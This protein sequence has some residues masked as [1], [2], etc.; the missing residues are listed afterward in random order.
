MPIYSAIISRFEDRSADEAADKII[1]HYGRAGRQAG[2]AF[3]KELAASLSKNKDFQQVMEQ[4]KRRYAEVGTSAKDVAEYEGLLDRARKTGLFSTQDTLRFEAQ[5][6]QARRRQTEAIKAQRDT[7]TQYQS[8]VRSAQAE[9]AK[10]SQLL[11]EH[12]KKVK[13]ATEEHVSFKE[14]LEGLGRL[15]NTA[16]VGRLGEQFEMLGGKIGGVT[17]GLSML[18]AGGAMGAATL[19]MAAMAGVVAA[20]G[21]GL[22]EYAKRLFEV[23]NAWDEM[24]KSIAFNTGLSG[25][26]LAELTGMV[27]ELSKTTPATAADRCGRR[28]GRAQPALDGRG[29]GHRHQADRRVQPAQRADDQHPPNRAGA[30][31]FRRRRQGRPALPRPD[32]HRLHP[33]RDRRR[34]DAFGAHPRGGDDETVRP[35]RFRRFGLLSE[36]DQAGVDITSVMPILSQDPQGCVGAS[37][38]VVPAVP[39]GRDH[40]DRQAR[41]GWGQGRCEEPG[42]Q[43]IRHQLPG[44]GPQLAGQEKSGELDLNSPGGGHPVAPA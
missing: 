32:L 19:G 34:P 1:G 10:H 2:E 9:L 28:P 43:D 24:T 18:G 17:S 39:Q 42:G 30:A 8:I 12:A 7:M 37:G 11:E 26:K 44:W 23:S 31:R 21:A 29:P 35:G 22:A 16:G 3:D 27:G 36:F 6:E 20:A 14:Q 41:Q 38:R 5:L 33:H 25:Q 13:A 4:L 15:S 40:A